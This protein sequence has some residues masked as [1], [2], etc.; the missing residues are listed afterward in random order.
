VE[1]NL[2][3]IRRWVERLSAACAGEAWREALMEAE[4]LEAEVRTTREELWERVRALPTERCGRWGA[5]LKGLGIA[6][7]LSLA[8]A[9]PIATEIERRVPVLAEVPGHFEWVAPDEESLLDAL[10]QSLSESNPGRPLSRGIPPSPQRGASVARGGGAGERRSRSD[11]ATGEGADRAPSDRGGGPDGIPPR[12]PRRRQPH[13][14]RTSSR[15]CRRGSGRS[16]APP[17]S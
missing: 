5:A 13:G 4:C 16:G 9:L 1:K 8:V 7:A 12:E 10:R 2:R 11:P 17:A 14:L 6:F 15:S 3:R